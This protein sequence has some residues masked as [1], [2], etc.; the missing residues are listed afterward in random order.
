MLWK[1]PEGL[2]VGHLIFPLSKSLEWANYRGDGNG[3]LQFLAIF[4]SDMIGSTGIL[5]SKPTG[6]GL[7]KRFQKLPYKKQDGHASHQVNI[8]G[9]WKFTLVEIPQPCQVALRC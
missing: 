3:V 1:K 8:S 5:D 7:K 2:Q 4:F 6:S 9:A